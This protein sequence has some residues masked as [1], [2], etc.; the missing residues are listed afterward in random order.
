[1]AERSALEHT[2]LGAEDNDGSDN[3][4]KPGKGFLDATTLGQ[5]RE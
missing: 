2:H 4:A 3:C 5:I 1:L